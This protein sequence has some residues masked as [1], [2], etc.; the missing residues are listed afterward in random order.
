MAQRMFVGGRTQKARNSLHERLESIL[1]YSPG[2][3][4][5]QLCR[6]WKDLINTTVE[7]EECEFVAC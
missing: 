4:V 3:I 5:A 1:F 7:G 2:T 6:C